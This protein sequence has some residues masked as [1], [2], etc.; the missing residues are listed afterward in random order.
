MLITPS[1]GGNLVAGAGLGV[2]SWS[3]FLKADKIPWLKKLLTTRRK[4]MALDWIDQNKGVTLLG[5]ETINLG[6]H[7]ILSPNAV[8]FALGNTVFNIFML[9]AYLPCRRMLD[10]KK[11]IKNVLKGAA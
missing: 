2:F 5:L 10:Q 7:G 9:W 4:G 6:I 8:I 11:R 1:N 3:A